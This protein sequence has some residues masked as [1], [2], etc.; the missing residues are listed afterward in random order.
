MNQIVSI[1]DFRR[2]AGFYID[3]LDYVG[4]FTLIRDGK[5]VGKIVSDKNT[6]IPMTT[7]EKVAKVRKLAGGFKLGIKLT[8]DQMNKEYNKMY[9]KMLPR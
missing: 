5:V 6:P 3:K 2:K 7:A 8:A 1:T 4:Y 9:A